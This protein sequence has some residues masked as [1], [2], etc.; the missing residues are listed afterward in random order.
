[1]IENRFNRHP[2]ITLILF[3]ILLLLS[4]DII[5]TRGVT[6]YLGKNY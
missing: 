1:M 6:F 2:K 5:L 4:L 3:S